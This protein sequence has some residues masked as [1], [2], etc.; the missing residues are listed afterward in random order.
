MKKL[1]AIIMV[2]AV[3]INLGGMAPTVYAS[4]NSDF[5]EV[6]VNKIWDR[7]EKSVL[8]DNSTVPSLGLCELGVGIYENGVGIT[9]FTSSTVEA[10]EIGITDFILY[11]KTLLG[12]D[13]ITIKDYCD[14]DTDHHSG[15]VIYVRAEAGKTYKASC[16]HYAIIDGVEYTLENESSEIVYN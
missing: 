10:E 12:W 15:S 13:E 5:I 8:T 4:E 6:E 2:L 7:Y 16:T 1:L 9:F 3:A 14:Y 11:E